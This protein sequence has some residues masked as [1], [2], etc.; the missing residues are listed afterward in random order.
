MRSSVDRSRLGLIACISLTALGAC[1]SDANMAM[2]LDSGSA[3]P[4]DPQTAEKASI[5]RFS[6][7]A[8]HLMVRDATNGLPGANGAIDFDSG[9][10]FITV[11]LGPSDGKPVKYYNFDVQPTGPAPIY[12]LF[13]DGETAPVSGQLNI[14]DVLPG[15]AGYNDFWQVTMVTVQGL[16][17]QRSHQF[18]RDP[19]RW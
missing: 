7:A 17:G 10:P 2:S 3:M 4:R 18:R 5:D 11:G 12:V 13:R 16:R 6:A 15:D 9:A 19:R 8:G 14:V 1:S